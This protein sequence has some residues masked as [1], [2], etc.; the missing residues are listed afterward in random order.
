[1]AEKYSVAIMPSGHV[2]V[3]V[4]KI[5]NELKNIIGIYSASSS[6]P[7]IT[8]FEFDADENKLQLYDRKIQLV[9]NTVE[10]FMISCKDFSEFYWNKTIYVALEERS[11]NLITQLRKKLS[12]ELKH[13]KYDEEVNF[14]SGKSP[15]ITIARTLSE[16]M[17]K[18]ATKY[19]HN[20]K[21]SGN[22]QCENIVLRKLVSASNFTKYEVVK[23]YTFAK[24][25]L[26]LF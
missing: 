3:D 18:T 4:I 23:P 15:H 11:T 26:T 13:G 25:N 2:K 12:A 7:Q 14:E 1:M 21:F 22:F 10:A 6:E 8:L 16:D 20:K 19:F 9:C 17:Y 24:Q 5:K